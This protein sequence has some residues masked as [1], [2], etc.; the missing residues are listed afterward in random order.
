MKAGEKAA[1]MAASM[2]GSK[3]ASMAVTMAG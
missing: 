1:L 2:V 3:A